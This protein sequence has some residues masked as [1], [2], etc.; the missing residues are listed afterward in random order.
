MKNKEIHSVLLLLLIGIGTIIHA[1]SYPIGSLEKMGPG[2]YPLLLGA[3]LVLL[4]VALLIAWILNG[5]PNDEIV[6][7]GTLRGWL[8]VIS[9][10]IAF[11][12]IGKYGGFIPATF[13]LITIAALGGRSRLSHILI[14]SSC[15]TVVAT[16][17]LIY[18]MQLQF[19]LFR[20]G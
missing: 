17:V 13:I 2:F 10:M 20:W 7:K 8:A 19:P 9:S 5:R 6:L 11:I 1:L 16:A 3:A 14:L 12:I 15:T 18:G 4:G